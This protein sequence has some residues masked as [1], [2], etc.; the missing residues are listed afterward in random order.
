MDYS[1]EYK[2]FRNMQLAKRKKVFFTNDFLKFDNYKACNKALERLVEQKKI[3]R[4]GRGTY[5]IPKKSDLLGDLPPTSDDIVKAIVK[6]DHAKIIPT[7]LLSENLLGLS[8]QV[9]AK[10]IYLTDGSPRKLQIDGGTIIFKKTSPKNLASKG[11]IS[12]LVIQALKSIRKDR[13][14]DYEIKKVVNH[15]KRENPK[16]VAHD[17]KYAPLWIR[18]IINKAIIKPENQ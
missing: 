18:E 1:I 16:Y 10:R 15:L 9:P 12:T 7:G 3:L 4:V 6:R 11:K 14:T 5:A 17:M 13:V 2:T 8:T